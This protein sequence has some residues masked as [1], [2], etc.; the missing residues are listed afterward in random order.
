MKYKNILFD[1]D[2]TL[3]DSK[4]GIV[5]SLREALLC[6]EINPDVM[7][8]TKFIGP[9]LMNTLVYTMGM[10]HKKADAIV[11]KYREHYS[12]TGVYN[13]SLYDGVEE[14]LSYL[15]TNGH[16]L[17]IATSK[18]LPFTNIVLEHFSISQYFNYVAASDFNRTFD[19]KQRIIED[20]LKNCNIIDLSSTVMIGDTK[21]DIT[22]AKAVGITAIGV[23]Y[24]YGDYEEL[25]A[26]GADFIV[27]DVK[28]LF[29]IIKDEIQ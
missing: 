1:L 23:L 3:T 10:E 27:K 18:P 5:N 9:P 16:A 2:G 28:E 12:D 11:K 20:I 8:L 25:S 24:G 26:S 22:A 4:P 21:F 13:N 29:N 14:M 7:D 17:F 19:T 6:F 15:K